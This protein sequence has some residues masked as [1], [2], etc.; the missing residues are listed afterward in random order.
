MT[1]TEYNETYNYQI[2]LYRC[3]GGY[4]ATDDI[5]NSNW[6]YIRGVVPVHTESVIVWNDPDDLK[7]SVIKDGE[8]ILISNNNEDLT[9]YDRIE[10]LFV[11]VGNTKFII[12]LHN[13]QSGRITRDSA[14]ELYSEILP[15]EAEA[16]V[17]SLKYADIN[18]ALRYWGGDAFGYGSSD[19]Y[20]TK[21]ES[22]DTYN[23]QICLYRYTGGYLATDNYNSEYGYI[24][25]VIVP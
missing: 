25:G 14:M 1:K 5:N 12:K 19:Y 21:T 15:T 7:L 4:L 10:G 8:R 20:M 6:G 16:R 9:Q 11:A 17:I 3:N 23:Y 22:N 2:N 18:S 13:E 24:R